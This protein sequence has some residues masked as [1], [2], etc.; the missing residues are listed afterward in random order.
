MAA[1]KSDTIV[2]K[3]QMGTVQTEVFAD[4]SYT[5]HGKISPDSPLAK[6]GAGPNILHGSSHGYQSVTLPG[7]EVLAFN[8]NVIEK[9]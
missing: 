5:I 2:V 7:G 1:R 8:V 6:G 3:A 9:V 4:G